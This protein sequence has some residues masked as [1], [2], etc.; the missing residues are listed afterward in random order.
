MKKWIHTSKD[1]KEDTD[2]CGSDDFLTPEQKE[3]LRNADTSGWAQMQ[4]DYME[5]EIRNA[6]SYGKYIEEE[7]KW[8]RR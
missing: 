8:N 5:D 7:R 6:G 4:T 3:A 2:V 1:Y